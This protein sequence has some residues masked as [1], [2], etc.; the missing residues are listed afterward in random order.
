MQK[1]ARTSTK[2]LRPQRVFPL[3]PQMQR[4]GNLR[5]LLVTI[6]YVAA[7]LCLIGV[8]SAASGTARTLG[9]KQQGIQHSIT[10]G[11]TSIAPKAG[12]RNQAQVA[13]SIPA[14][15]A[16]IVSM[17]QGPF[18]TSVFRVSN[19]WQG[20]VDNTWVLAYA[21]AQTR[22]DGTTGQGAI[23]LYIE[24]AN[25]QG[26]FYLHPLGTFL[27][28]GGTTALTITAGTS[29]LLHVNS[30]S[31]TRACSLIS[32]RTS[33]VHSCDRYA[34]RQASSPNVDPVGKRIP[35][36]LSTCGASQWVGWCWWLLGPRSSSHQHQAS[37]FATNSHK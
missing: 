7:F 3:H 19:L 9:Q 15:K 16:G 10:T 20:P 25:T 37:R 22:S 36:L 35:E 32:S 17:K 21:G 28:P 26:G 24:T 34:S 11:K 23:V 13:Q 29:T 1:R 14:R 4:R 2:K 30:E 6:V 33:S 31:G 18:P 5:W 12:R 8:A 27:A